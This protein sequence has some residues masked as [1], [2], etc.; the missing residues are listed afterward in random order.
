MALTKAQADAARRTLIRETA[1]RPLTK[2]QLKAV[3]KVLVATAMQRGGTKESAEREARSVLSAAITE[4]QVKAAVKKRLK[5]TAKVGR[6]PIRETMTAAQAPQPGPDTGLA[7]EAMTTDELAAQYL[8]A[9]AT[10]MQTPFWRTAG[11]A[12]DSAKAPEPAKPLHQMDADELRAYS[13]GALTTY[14]RANGF[15]SPA[16]A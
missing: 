16:W 1:T 15:S 9:G 5:E 10:G 14:G 11:T 12:A 7:P 4:S 13:A 2:K 3:K 8:T 6:Q